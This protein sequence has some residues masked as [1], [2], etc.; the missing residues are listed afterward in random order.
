M[1]STVQ[2]YLVWTDLCVYLH[3]C[4]L[5][6]STHVKGGLHWFLLQ[7]SDEHP[8]ERPCMLTWETPSRGWLSSDM[9]RPFR[10]AS[11][12]QPAK[13]NGKE[14]S[15]KRSTLLTPFTYKDSK[16][17]ETELS[18]MLLLSKPTIC[19]RQIPAPVVHIQCQGYKKIV[20]FL[21]FLS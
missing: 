6:K 3:S 16:Y 12:M 21:F 14:F 10:R 18:L 2:L 11:L 4:T 20:L 13:K 9:Q 8:R 7:E 19:S 17:N 15:G 5:H 1:C